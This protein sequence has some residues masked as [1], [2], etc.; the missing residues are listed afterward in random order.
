MEAEFKDLFKVAKK[1]KATETKKADPDAAFREALEAIPEELKDSKFVTAYVR[2]RIIQRTKRELDK[3]EKE[4]AQ[5]ALA[6]AKGAVEDKG[7]LL[8]AWRSKDFQYELW[9]LPNGKYYREVHARPGLRL[10]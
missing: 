2:R 7:E 10:T 4:T 1:E 5:A 3:A 6:R 9:Q 8:G